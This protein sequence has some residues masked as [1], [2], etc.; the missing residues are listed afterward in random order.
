MRYN[1]TEAGG[2]ERNEVSE[3]NNIVSSHPPN[4]LS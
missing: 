1:T 3:D 2:V 4:L